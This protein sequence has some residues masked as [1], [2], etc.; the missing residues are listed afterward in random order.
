MKPRAALSAAVIMTVWK[1][2]AD[3]G[4]IP[5]ILFGLRLIRQKQTS[6]KQGESLFLLMFC[7]TIQRSISSKTSRHHACR[8]NITIIP[9]REM[10]S[11]LTASKSK[12]PV[13]F[14]FYYKQGLH[15]QNLT[16][17]TKIPSC[18][19]SLMQR[20]DSLTECT[21]LLHPNDTL[22]HCQ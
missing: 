6:L 13:K 9:V 4:D 18:A 5:V 19:V 1:H 22:V 11:L 10:V 2:R 20:L 3:S 21:T 12:L 14:F 8:L 7:H 16:P 15:S 17:N